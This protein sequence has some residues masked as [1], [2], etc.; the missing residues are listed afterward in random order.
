M[1]SHLLFADD[2]FLFFQAA[3]Q[4]VGTIKELLTLYESP[5]R[6]SIK[7]S[8]NIRLIIARM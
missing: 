2:S 6:Q 3:D 1:I 5:S 4:E 7:T 8:R